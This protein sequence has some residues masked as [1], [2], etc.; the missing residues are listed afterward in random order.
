MDGSQASLYTKPTHD[1]TDDVLY[2]LRK[3]KE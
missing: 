2:E 3:S 1:L